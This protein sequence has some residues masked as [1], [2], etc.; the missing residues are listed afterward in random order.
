MGW[1]NA[2]VTERD[3][4]PGRKPGDQQRRE[5]L[6]GAAVYRLVTHTASISLVAFAESANS[7]LSVQAGG[8]R[9]LT[10]LHVHVRTARDAETRTATSTFTQ[11]RSFE[12]VG[13]VEQVFNPQRWLEGTLFLSGLLTPG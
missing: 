4:V 7:R 8:R 5:I 3:H 12:A 9:K 2:A 1:V 11:L 6:C 13:A 10:L